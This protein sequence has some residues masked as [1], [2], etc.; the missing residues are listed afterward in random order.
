[1]NYPKKILRKKTPF[2]IN[3]K[4]KILCLNVQ[5]CLTLVT[6]WTI[7]CQVPLSMGI[8]QARMLEIYYIISPEYNLLT[9]LPTY[10]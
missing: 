3:I 8:I 7:P 2:L 5:S 4:N 6:P 10:K 1:M 9:S